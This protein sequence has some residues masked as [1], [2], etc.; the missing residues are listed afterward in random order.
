MIPR[1]KKLPLLITLVACL[2]LSVLLA[3]C[4][5]APDHTDAWLSIKYSPGCGTANQNDP[6]FCTGLA[7]TGEADSYYHA[8]GADMLI[9]PPN[10]TQFDAWLA[11]NPFPAGGIS[12]ALYANKG[13]LQIGRDMN[14][15]QTGQNVACYVTNY[16]VPPFD[17]QA[18]A[19]AGGWPDLEGAVDDAI[20][21]NSPFA[22]VAMVY[23]P[24]GTGVNK[25]KV[26]FYVFDGAGVLTNQAALDGEGFKTV[27]RMCMACHGGTYDKG[28]HSATGI[29]FL[30]FDVQFFYYSQNHKEFGI[31]EQQEAFRQ[32]NSLV[33]ATQP[34]Q[35]IVAFVNGIYNNNVNVAHTAV[36]D[37]TYIPADWVTGDPNSQKIYKGVFRKY[38]RMCHVASAV[39]PFAKYSD[40]QANAGQISSL[41]CGKLPGPFSHDMPHAEVPFGGL[42]GSNNNSYGFWM[43]G[44]AVS[45]LQKFLK[46]NNAA[47]P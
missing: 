19:Q 15:W 10:G 25:D 26:V 33:L 20:A 32:L 4:T 3:G 36:P 8:I 2:S 24:N 30:P 40:F 45:D 17:F 23:N 16:G 13:D 21:R 44:T 7:D 12:R 29:N 5:T 38:C 27:P 11:Q 1:A 41:V 18:Q 6:R 42:A 14:C 37:D 28:T 39:L 9:A 46:S 31:D 34:I 43:D 35:G 22:T 47:C